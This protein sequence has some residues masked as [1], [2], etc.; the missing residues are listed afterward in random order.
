[1]KIVKAGRHFAVV[2]NNEAVVYLKSKREAEAWIAMA[3]KRR[4]EDAAYEVE[5]RAI[6]VANAKAY[7]E[8]RAS[9]PSASQLSLF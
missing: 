6:R 8:S 2:E 9:R 1:M 4:I 3:E 5:T 7:L